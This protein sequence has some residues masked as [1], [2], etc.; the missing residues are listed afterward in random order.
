[1]SSVTF[2]ADLMSQARIVWESEAKFVISSSK[3]I[4]FAEPLLNILF[5]DVGLIF[6]FVLVIESQAK[7][8][9][10]GLCLTSASSRT[11]VLISIPELMKMC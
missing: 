4:P 2:N 9:C 1:M 7:G 3:K 10:F 5:L 6:K 8:L 11:F